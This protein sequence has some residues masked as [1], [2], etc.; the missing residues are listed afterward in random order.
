MPRPALR[1]T[2]E[3]VSHAVGVVEGAIAQLVIDDDRL[4]GVGMKDGHFVPREALFIPPRF[5]PNN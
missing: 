5:V 4:R 1:L 3:N 2:P